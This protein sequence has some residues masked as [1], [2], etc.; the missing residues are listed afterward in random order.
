MGGGWGGGSS[1]LLQDLVQQDHWKKT[2]LVPS[3]LLG[4]SRGQHQNARCEVAVTKIR[5][6][7]QYE[8]AIVSVFIEETACW[9]WI[10][11]AGGLH[12]MRAYGVVL[13]SLRTHLYHDNDK[14]VDCGYKGH[15]RGSELCDQ[16]GPALKLSPRVV[17]LSIPGD[18]LVD[19]AVQSSPEPPRARFSR[20]AGVVAV[21]IRCAF[22]SC[23]D[24]RTLGPVA[25]VE[26]EALLERITAHEATT[27]ATVRGAVR[28]EVDGA[29]LFCL[30]PLARVL[31]GVRCRMAASKWVHEKLRPLI[32][33]TCTDREAAAVRKLGSAEEEW[34]RDS[35]WVAPQDVVF[36]ALAPPA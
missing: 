23:E 17:D 18:P 12:A 15:G 25:R 5:S 4:L 9:T 33:K 26:R 35:P 10:D 1:G 3:C 22:P 7:K 30:V 32:K 16:K 14:C 19:A 31:T 36:K 6:R 20:V 28:R 13:T 2:P 21:E 24:W 11:A 27:S 29:A 8:T 34:S